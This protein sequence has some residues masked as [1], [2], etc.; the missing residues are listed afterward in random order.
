M[1]YKRSLPPPTT[2]AIRKNQEIISKRNMA[3]DAGKSAYVR[4]KYNGLVEVPAGKKGPMGPGKGR[5]GNDRFKKKPGNPESRAMAARNAAIRTNQGIVSARNMAADAG[6][7]T[8]VRGKNAGLVAV[9]KVMVRPRLR[10]SDMDP[11]MNPRRRGPVG[12]SPKGGPY[13]P[14]PRREP[15]DRR[16]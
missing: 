14:R 8:Y 9:P 10:P 2:R 11:G 4:G 12:P 6:R 16:A 3:V 7:S 15:G 13:R 1:V 5:I